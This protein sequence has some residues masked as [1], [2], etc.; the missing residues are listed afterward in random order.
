[1]EGGQPPSR[2]IH[3][4]VIALFELNAL[5]GSRYTLSDAGVAVYLLPDDVQSLF[6]EIA[7]HR[8]VPEGDDDSRE[9]L[10]KAILHAVAVD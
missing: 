6:I 8:L 10:A 7:S 4:R 1:M 9:R 5:T 2:F 3:I